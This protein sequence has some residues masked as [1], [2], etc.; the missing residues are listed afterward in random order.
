MFRPIFVFAALM[1]TS[2]FSASTCFGAPEGSAAP[3][4]ST[5]ASATATASAMVVSLATVEVQGYGRVTIWST[6]ERLARYKVGQAS[7]TV[8][9]SG[10]VECSDAE[11]QS[12]TQGSEGKQTFNVP[13]LD[14]DFE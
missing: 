1:L 12:F 14:I 8:A 7:C 11:K 13:K 9:P 4:P 3:S 5:S 10:A 6:A 2:F